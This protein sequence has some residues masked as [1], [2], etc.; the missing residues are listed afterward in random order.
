M[1]IDKMSGRLP[2]DV[3]SRIES[4]QVTPVSESG[5]DEFGFHRDYLK[6]AA[7]LAL[8]LY[9]RWFR[10]EAVGV[11]NVPLEG[12]AVIVPNHSGLLP[13][14]GMMIAVACLLEMEKPRL[15]RAMIEK[16]FP[17]VPNL[18]ILMPRVGQVTGLTENAEKLLANGELV[19]IFPEGAL[20]AGKTWDKRYRLQRFT[21]G[22]MELAIRF[23]APVVPAAVIGGEEQAP[24]LHNAEGVA[25]ALGMPYFPLTPTF[26]WAGLL[27]F[28]P[29]PSRYH[30]YFGAP[31]DFS[32]ERGVLADPDAVRALVE[33]VREHVQ[34]MVAEGLKKRRF[35]GF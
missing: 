21:V 33:R 8:F 11:G 10:V 18:A 5:Y 17:T 16:W 24:N 4:L 6:A 14:D 3:L 2:D 25:R 15:P 28:I 26:P 27:G 29:F 31:M 1:I 20:G 19:L 12:P 7:P 9:R 13:F 22:F 32:G 30:I 35:P 34:K 23:G